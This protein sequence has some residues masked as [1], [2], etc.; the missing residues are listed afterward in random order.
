MR[1]VL[2]LDEGTTGTTALVIAEDG[3]VVGRGY[4]EITQHFPQP[5][6]VEHD[7]EEI[8]ARTIEAAREALAEAKVTPEAIGITNQRETIVVW[9]RKTGKPIDK[10]IVWQDRRTTRRAA[11]LR[12][13]GQAPAIYAATG[14]VT[15]PYF[16]ATKLEWLLKER[17]RGI[18]PDTLAAGTID[19]WLI[20]KLTNGAVHATDYTNASR[21]MLF[22]IN[23]RDWSE[24]LC[25]LFGV[26]REILPEVRPSSGS[27]GE[28]AKEHLG[29]ALPILGVAGDQQSA[30]FGQGCWSPG[31]SKNTYGTGAFLLFNTGATRPP[32]GQG[33][34]T[35]ITCDAEGKPV[36]ALEASIFIAGAAVQW[37][38]DGL[39]IVEKASETEAM[40]RSLERNDGVYFV[41]ALTGLGAPHWEPEARGTI[42]GLTRGT[43]REHLVRAA[44]EAMAYS[45]ADVLE[46]MRGASGAP[47]DVLRVD[48][49]AAQN[50]WL[51]QFQSDVLGVPVERPDIVETTALGAAGLAGI[52]GGVWSD[53]KAFHASRTF[54]RFGPTAGSNVARQG[55]G[56]WRRATRAAVHWARDRED[57]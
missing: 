23:T 20:W 15:D 38:R 57:G 14:L 37:L 8:F 50:D 48:G 36:Y 17:A 7:A 18:A 29:V 41:P 43:S 22:D 11:A 24:Q 55:L 33:M 10:A 42:V 6:W 30:M 26:P 25:A 39:G 54:T 13:A 27:F 9:D 12:E 31:Q 49:G 28:S 21:T 35:T 53:A 1:H 52:A 46:A 19:T 45:T 4:R 2:A 5:G 56:G 47:L 51:M 16:S 32:G 34:L 40:A 3:R 44:L